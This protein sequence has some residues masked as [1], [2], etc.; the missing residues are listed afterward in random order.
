M[1]LDCF[2]QMKLDFLKQ[3]RARHKE[4][5]ELCEG[6]LPDVVVSHKQEAFKDRKD[7]LVYVAIK[8]LKADE[9]ARTVF[10]DEAVCDGW[11]LA[12]DLEFE[13]FP[14]GME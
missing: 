4:V 3:I 7:Y 12:N 6:E 2:D 11:C 8:Y 14:G 1:K 5:L 9:S 10:F 13:F